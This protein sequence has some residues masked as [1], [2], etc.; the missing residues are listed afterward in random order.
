[1]WCQFCFPEPTHRLCHQ[2]Q[3]SHNYTWIRLLRTKNET[4]TNRNSHQKS[5]GLHVEATLSGPFTW[6]YLLLTYPPN[7]S[8][9]SVPFLLSPS[10]TFCKFVYSPKPSDSLAELE[11][12]LAELDPD[13]WKFCVLCPLITGVTGQEGGLPFTASASPLGPTT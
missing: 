2:N 4:K 9:F 7:P 8:S 5:L 12:D 6:P 11:L 3:Q 1:M 10:P 13:L